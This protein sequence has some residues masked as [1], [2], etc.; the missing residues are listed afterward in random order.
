MRA[1]PVHDARPTVPVASR[2]DEGAATY[3]QVRRSADLVSLDGAF[4][5]EMTPPECFAIRV[6]NRGGIQTYWF[7]GPFGD[8]NARVV[9][10]TCVLGDRLVHYVGGSIVGG[11]PFIQ[12]GAS[13]AG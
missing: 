10:R 9:A 2:P 7:R 11:R 12:R 3:A 13:R 5:D 6:R 8:L 4:T 1:V